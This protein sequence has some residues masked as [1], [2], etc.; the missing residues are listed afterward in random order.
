[1]LTLDYNG[2]SWYQN[3]AIF[4][5]AGHDIVKILANKNNFYVLSENGPSNIFRCFKLTEDLE[6]TQVGK[7][8][9]V[10]QINPTFIDEF[11]SC[12]ILTGNI[13]IV[14]DQKFIKIYD[15]SNAQEQDINAK[16]TIQNFFNFLP[17]PKKDEIGRYMPL[18]AIRNSP[19]HNRILMQ[20]TYPSS[21][22]PKKIMVIPY[23][24]ENY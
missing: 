17:D 20:F 24:S 4:S 2:T 18:L 16:P 23:M 8:E 19:K 3:R 7:L 12:P 15:T 22:N 14:N 13:L 10:R 21:C 9:N 5:E 11:K 6:L 1:M